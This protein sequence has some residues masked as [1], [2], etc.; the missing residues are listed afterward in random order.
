MQN[1][2][3]VKQEKKHIK[4]KDIEHD[5][6]FVLPKSTGFSTCQILSVRI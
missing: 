2:K 5:K 4:Q 6:T 1:K 3:H